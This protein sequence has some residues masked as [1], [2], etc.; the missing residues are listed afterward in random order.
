M[1]NASYQLQARLLF[2]LAGRYQDLSKLTF[3][4]ILNAKKG[5]KE[6]EDMDEYYIVD[7]LPQKT[8]RLRM[9]GL[10]VPAFEQV[11][12]FFEMRHNP[13]EIPGDQLIWPEMK[14]G[15]KDDVK[16]E[17]RNFQRHI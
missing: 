10:S 9:L 3:G 11:R 1:R 12:R 7:L 14:G 5:E 4:Q 6:V 2:E 16:R 15:S 8:D 17:G 13:N